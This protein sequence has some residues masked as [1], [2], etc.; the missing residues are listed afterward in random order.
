MYLSY[1]DYIYMGGTLDESTFSICE[2]QAESLIDWYTFDRLKKET[3][4]TKEVRMCMFMLI[5]LIDNK[6]K[7]LSA[8][9]ESSPITSQSNDGVSTT[10]AVLS[11]ADLI[12]SNKEEITS[13][14]NLCLRNAV[15]S[16]G[17]QLLYRG[18]YPGE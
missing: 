3:E 18:F 10:Y 7:V 8:N 9:T 6:S 15:N 2:F 12:A 4:F 16:M 1:D 14:I 5:K 13:T 11:S 17:K